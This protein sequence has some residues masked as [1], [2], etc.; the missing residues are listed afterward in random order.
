VYGK[1]EM[2]G[3][4]DDEE[5]EGENATGA[6]SREQPKEGNEEGTIGT[7]LLDSGDYGL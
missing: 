7:R 5:G 3:L 4:S 6:K 1:F 2:A